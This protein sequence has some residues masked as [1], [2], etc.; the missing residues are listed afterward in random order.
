MD[1]K[2][3]L[4]KC[5]VVTPVEEIHNDPVFRYVKRDDYF[6]PFQDLPLSGGKVR[7]AILLVNNNIDLIREELGNNIWTA[8]SMSSP[9]GVIVSRVASEYG[10]NSKLFIGS[11][12]SKDSIS[13]NNLMMNSYGCGSSIDYDSR[14]A[15]ETALQ[16]HIK[17]VA[18]NT[19]EKFFNVKFG[20]N[21]DTSP[22][23][24]VASTAMQVQNIPD[25]LDN[26]VVPSGSCIILSGVILGCLM[27]NKTVDNIIGVQIAGY[28]RCKTIDH[29][30]DTFGIPEGNSL[31]TLEKSK[32]YPYSRLLKRYTI[33]TENIRLD[34]LY[35][36]KGY[37]YCLKHMPEIHGKENLFWIVGDSTDIRN[38]KPREETVERFLYEN[39]DHKKTYG[40]VDR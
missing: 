9:Q 14:Q 13:K 11:G 17:K 34:P 1:K 40:G 18:D 4:S 3:L 10:V 25:H 7:Q 21:L 26:L 23:A 16:A 22:E 30:L 32:D 12:C 5:D 15:F 24:L 36:S 37:D 19:G 20:I 27:F 28:D 29:I 35:E 31:Y 6:R 39:R 2:E 8:T 38:L 33:G